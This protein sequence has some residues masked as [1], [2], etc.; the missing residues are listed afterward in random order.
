MPIPTRIHRIVVVCG[1]LGAPGLKITG[2]SIRSVSSFT[3]Y[4]TTFRVNLTFILSMLASASRIGQATAFY[5]LR[6]A[7]APRRYTLSSLLHSLI[8]PL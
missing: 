1:V 3:A 8:V 6:I 4:A 7:R 5:T 2:F